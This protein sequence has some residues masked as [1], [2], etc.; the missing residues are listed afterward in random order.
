MAPEYIGLDQK[1]RFHFFAR[2][3]SHSRLSFQ[4]QA[5]QSFL[6]DPGSSSEGLPGLL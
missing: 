6:M 2:S 1:Q 5:L 4:V 3:I